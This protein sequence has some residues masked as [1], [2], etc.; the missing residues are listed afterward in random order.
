MPNDLPENTTIYVTITPFNAVGDATGC[1]EE[2]FTTG[3][4]PAAPTC[5]SLSAPL[6]GATNVAVDT[7]LSWN[8]VSDV[9][10]Y[11]ITVGTTPG[12]TDIINNQNVG[13][14]TTFDLPN[15]LPENTT[16]FV[17]I[18]PFNVV[19][20]ATACVEES[21]TTEIIPVVPNC[22]T[23]SN[24]LDGATNV[25][26]DTDLSWNSVSDVTG[27]RITVGTT[28]GGT[29][30]INNQNV[31]NVTTFDL[32]NDLPENTTI[33]VAITPFN[34]VGDAT[35]CT[36]ESFTTEVIPTVPEC[37]TLLIP[38]NNAVNV[39]TDTTI[40]WD[41]VANA[42]GYR[43][44]IGTTPGGTDIINN[45]NVGNVTFINLP[46]ALP[47]GTTIY[48]TIIPFNVIG[49]AIGCEQ[50][51]FT[52]TTTDDTKYGFSP[53]GDGINEFWYIDGIENYP[54]NQVTIFNRQGS[55]VFQ[56]Q[57]YNNASR[58][59]SGEA[60]RLRNLGAN[61]LPEG[62]YFFDIKINGPNNLRK[63]QGFLVLKR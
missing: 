51:S 57:G 38:V 48:V 49:D 60:N 10:G 31:G 19:G 59:F 23:L 21:F 33:Y 27:Y 42:T 6:D 50:E 44:T 1:T 2:S 9:T 13:N 12:G 36:E 28:P 32:P 3:T 41:V 63:L 7:N 45:Q 37:T 47:E 62:T 14:V 4:A 11:R 56:I 29:D 54:D 58:V 40:E 25:A 55:I 22:T 20:M 34:A 53:D 8:S 15:D 43:I 24:P 30:I 46:N 52:T 35:G 16:I 26:V 17:T 5:T 18:N 39:A 61:T